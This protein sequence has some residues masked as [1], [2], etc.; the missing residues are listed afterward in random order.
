MG[1][2]G[3]SNKKLQKYARDTMMKSMKSGTFRCRYCGKPKRI[4]YFGSND[5]WTCP[6]CKQKNWIG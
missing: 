3:N 2:F 5:S 1:L 6:N 4:T